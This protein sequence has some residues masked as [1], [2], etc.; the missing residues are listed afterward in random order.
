MVQ[1]AGGGGCAVTP[2]GGTDVSNMA[3]AEADV[4]KSLTSLTDFHS[5]LDEDEEYDRLYVA[6]LER[7]E[8]GSAGA[9]DLP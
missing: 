5:E 3:V 7:L 1:G 6:V 8:G 4:G 2:T 9:V